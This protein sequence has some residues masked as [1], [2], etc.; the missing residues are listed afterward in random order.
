MFDR[1]CKERRKMQLIS[2]VDDEGAEFCVMCSND[3]AIVDGKVKDYAGI[4]Q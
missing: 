3:K 4:D 2:I 1:C